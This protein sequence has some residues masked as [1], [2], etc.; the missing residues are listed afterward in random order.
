[1]AAPDEEL[2]GKAQGYP[3]CSLAGALTEERCFV[4]GFSHFDE[5][6]PAHRVAKSPILRT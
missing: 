4:W 2:L 3:V 1:L 6:I 5:L